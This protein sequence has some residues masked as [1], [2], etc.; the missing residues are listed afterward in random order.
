MTPPL[1]LRGREKMGRR[2]QQQVG[3]A[4]EK[5]V[6]IIKTQSTTVTPSRKEELPKLTQG[7]A[8]KLPFFS[9]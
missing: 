1:R 8:K 2:D 9:C 4:K 3:W 7:Q 5:A 6:D